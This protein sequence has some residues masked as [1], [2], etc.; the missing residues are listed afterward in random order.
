LKKLI[1]DGYWNLSHSR[2]TV[3]NQADRYE[4]NEKPSDASR[5]YQI[6]SN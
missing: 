6:R 5:T 1:Q 3:D 2:N 4:D